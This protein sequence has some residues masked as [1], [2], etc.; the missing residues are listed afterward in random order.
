MP[1]AT[2]RKVE[3]T[4]AAAAAL[5]GVVAALYLAFGPVTTVSSC[6]ATPGAPSVCETHTETLWESGVEPVAVAFLAAVAVAIL[7]VPAMAWAHLAGHN[8]HARRTLCVLAAL[9]VVAAVLSGFSVGLLLLPA[10]LLAVASA[11]ASL[12]VEQTPDPASS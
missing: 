11:A 9:L 1:S 4:T 12:S 8:G 5:F 3:L 7:L 6:S 2:A 10:A